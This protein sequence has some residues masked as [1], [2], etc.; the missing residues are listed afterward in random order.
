MCYLEK[1]SLKDNVHWGF[2]VSSGGRLKLSQVVSKLFLS[3]SIY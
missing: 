3:V 2:L 1:G